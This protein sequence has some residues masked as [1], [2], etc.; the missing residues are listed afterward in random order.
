MRSW[1]ADSMRGEGQEEKTA[2][3]VRA[4]DWCAA[5]TQEM[6]LGLGLL[7]LGVAC[8]L[9]VYLLSFPIWRDE[10]ALALNLASRDFRGLLHELDNYQIAPLF[11]LWIEKAVYSYLGGTAEL[12]RL[13]PLLAGAAGL[14]LFWRLARLSLAPLPAALALGCLAVASSPIHLASMVKPYSLDLFLATL[15]LTLAMAYLRAPHR[16]GRLAALAFVI[17]FA[18]PAS[19][20]VVFVAGGVSLVL[21]PVVWRQGRWAGRCWFAAFNVLCVAVFL[22]HLQLVGHADPEWKVDAVKPYMDLYWKEAFLPR[23][24]LPALH[25]FIR[26]HMGHMLSYPLEWNGG[27]LL[28]LVLSLTG[29][30]ALYRRR[31]Y[32]LLGLCLAPFALNFV[33]GALHRYPYAGDQRVEQHL[34]PGLCLLLGAGAAELIQR[35]TAGAAGQ[36]RWAASLAGLFVLIALAGVIADTFR[37]YHDVEA[38]WARDIVGHLRREVRPQDQIVPLQ[39]GRETLDCLRWQL[40]PLAGQ[41]RSSAQIEWACPK[42]AGGRLWIVDQGHEPAPSVAGPPDRASHGVLLTLERMGWH[43]IGRS[44]FLASGPGPLEQRVYHYCCDLHILRSDG[45]LA[46]TTVKPP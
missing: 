26:C 44:R 23:E 28:G 38:R 9:Y 4:E 15:L 31:Q 22:A 21:L 40:V 25:W 30:C 11:F 13:P 5:G 1:F 7:V 18:V 19:Y 6:W 39:P 12:L 34:V 46:E 3:P 27:G 41:V 43:A 2:F 16:N 37:P 32:G 45:P 20:P 10:A 35:L 29:A 14:V 24:P 36:R 17:P 42:Q 8:R 33:A